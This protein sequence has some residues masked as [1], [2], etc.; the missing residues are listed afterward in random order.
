MGNDGEPIAECKGVDRMANAKLIAS[1]PKLLECTQRL[2]ERLEAVLK[3]LGA[4]ETQI[5][6]HPD[7]IEARNTITKATK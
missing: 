1:A 6:T 4:T 2:A 5:I 3:L 7:L